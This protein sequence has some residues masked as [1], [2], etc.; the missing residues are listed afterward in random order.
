M[1]SAR[2]ALLS[3]FLLQAA[4]ALPAAEV[5]VSARIRGLLLGAYLGDAL[6]GPVEFQDPDKV[7]ALPDPPKRWGDD[8]ILDAPARA[9]AA[10]RLRL[11]PYAPLRPVSES[12]GQWG[13]NCPPGTVTDDSRHKLV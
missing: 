6:G 4:G 7:Q 12:Y 10:A 5:D 1:I 3:L 13:T 8:E 11:R 2:A 9:A